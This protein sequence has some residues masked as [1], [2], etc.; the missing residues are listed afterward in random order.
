MSWDFVWYVIYCDFAHSSDQVQEE[1]VSHNQESSYRRG[2]CSPWSSSGKYKWFCS[3]H[4]LFS[5]VY[6]CMEYRYH[7][8]FYLN[9][10]HITWFLNNLTMKSFFVIQSSTSGRLISPY[11]YFWINAMEFGKITEFAICNP[12]W[13]G[14]T[15]NHVYLQLV[16]YFTGK[17]HG[18]NGDHQHMAS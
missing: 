7:C 13:L 5:F 1:E 16:K 9:M 17:Y 18:Y 8:C 3:C 11:E 15:S 4:T 14:T 2:R 10:F 6:H 12:Y